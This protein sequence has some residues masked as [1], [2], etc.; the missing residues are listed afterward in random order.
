MNVTINGAYCSP[1]TTS[2][3][4]NQNA[5]KFEKEYPKAAKAIIDKHYLDDYVC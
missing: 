5:M 1:C 2:Y 3:A 4:K